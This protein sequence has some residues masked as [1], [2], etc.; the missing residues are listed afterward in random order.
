MHDRHPCD[1][2]APKGEKGMILSRTASRKREMSSAILAGPREPSETHLLLIWY[3]WDVPLIQTGLLC[4]YVQ[5]I[6]DMPE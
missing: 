6:M 2:A 5:P 4:R 3:G 1:L